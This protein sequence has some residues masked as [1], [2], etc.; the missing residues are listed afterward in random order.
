MESGRSNSYGA[1]SALDPGPQEAGEVRGTARGRATEPGSVGDGVREA[2]TTA[3]LSLR[4]VGGCYPTLAPRDEVGLER[5]PD[6]RK[7]Q[8]C[9][10]TLW[11]HARN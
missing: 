10:L 11:T 2:R 4:D 6:L 9:T 1:L 3:E 8:L 5:L 7:L